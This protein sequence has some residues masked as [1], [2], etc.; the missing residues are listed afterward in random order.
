MNSITNLGSN[1][2]VSYATLSLVAVAVVSS[3]TSIAL[4]IFIQMKLNN[5]D[6]KNEIEVLNNTIKTLSKE[7]AQ[8]HKNL[9]IFQSV[10]P[11]GKNSNKLINAY[12]TQQRICRIGIKDGLSTAYTNVS[13]SKLLVKDGELELTLDIPART[14]SRCSNT[15]KTTKNITVAL[16][17][18]ETAF[19]IAD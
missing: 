3:L 10:I 12:C 11:S 5:G 19:F 14:D 2:N 7:L 1:P 4:A 18:I 9:A 16:Q 13:I 8:T 15:D 6:K 17:N